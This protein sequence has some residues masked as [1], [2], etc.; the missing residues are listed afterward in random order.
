MGA[1][2]FHG[3]GG[4]DDRSSSGEASPG[5][6]NPPALDHAERVKASFYNDIG[7]IERGLVSRRRGET[8]QRAKIPG[9]GG[10]YF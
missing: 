10:G 4:L 7:K 1:L 6:N 9:S 5:G 3:V 2:S 8:N